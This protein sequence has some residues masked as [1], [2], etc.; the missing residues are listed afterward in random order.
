MIIPI[1]YEKDEVFLL[2]NDKN[3]CKNE[4]LLDYRDVG[5]KFLKQEN[6]FYN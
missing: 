1:A 3:I 5:L 4:L 6:Y 2:K